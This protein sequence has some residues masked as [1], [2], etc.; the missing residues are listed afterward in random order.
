MRNGMSLY[1]SDRLHQ[2]IQ[3]GHKIIVT[4]P[5]GEFEPGIFDQARSRGL[6]QV[7]RLSS[8]PI[9]YSESERLKIVNV[10]LMDQAKLTMNRPLC[11]GPDGKEFL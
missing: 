7:I 11:L 2:M 4:D 5:K 8:P 1:F 6:C 9:F 10:L 3:A